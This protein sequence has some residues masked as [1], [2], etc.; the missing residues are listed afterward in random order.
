ME[1]IEA[2]TDPRLLDKTVCLKLNGGLGTS[3]GLDRAKSLLE[4]K[5]GNSFLDFICKQSIHQLEKN[6][7]TMK[8]CFMNSFSTSEDTLSATQKYAEKLEI[9]ELMQN[10]SPKVDAA[11]MLP[12][13]YAEDPECEWCPPGHGDL[14]ACLIGSGVLDQLLADGYEY[15]FVSN[16]D[17]LGATMDV[18]ILNHFAASESPFMMEVCERTESDK[19]GGHLAKRNSDG[20]LVLRESAMC[21]DKDKE[22]FQDITKHRFFNTNSLWLRLSKL[23]AKMDASGGVLK[24]PLIKNSKTVNPRD[25]ASAKVFQLE[26]AMGAAVECFEG[27]GAI[28]VPRSRFAPVK[29]CSDLL[30]L[31]SD[32]YEITD[33]FRPILREACASLFISLDDDHY[34]LVDQMESKMKRGVP[35]LAG[36]TRLT[37]KGPVSMGSGVIF[38]GVVEV[39]TT[40]A[41]TVELADGNYIA[42][43]GLSC[44][45]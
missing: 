29:K 27:A 43:C 19:K 38:K 34:T 11:T 22:Q 44:G 35:S 14:Y 15:M 4:V 31:R 2:N 18:A 16:S 25:K 13:T 40:S 23:K 32:A 33:D 45:L 39:T 30:M 20:G 5:D 36:C 17:N 28:V 3:M 1:S 12:A 21:D 41:S 10:K 7:S 42:S 9:L 24:L 26:T 37:V 6:K 8:V